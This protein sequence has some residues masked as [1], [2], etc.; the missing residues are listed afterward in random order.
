M[1]KPARSRIL[2]INFVGSD[3]PM[4]PN[5]R[6]AVLLVSPLRAEDRRRQEIPASTLVP[7]RK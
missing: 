5:F 4:T 6:R 1:G 7:D 3:L 2:G